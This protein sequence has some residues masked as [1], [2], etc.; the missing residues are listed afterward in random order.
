MKIVNITHACL[1]FYFENKVL[2]TDPWI[3]KDPIKA[4]MVYK[5]PRMRLSSKKAVKNV[6]YCYISHTHEDHFHI[7]SLQKLNK[8][9]KMIIPDF[10]QHKKGRRGR[11]MADTLKKMGFTNI[12]ELKPWKLYE[13]TNKTKIQI[14]PSA[15]SRYF[16]W[17]N[18]GL[19]LIHDG[20]SYLNM[21]DN[22]V[23]EALCRE[24][25]KKIKNIEIYFIQTAGI[26][27]FP[28]CFEMS[29]K[30]KLKKIKHKAEDYKLHDL[31]TKI[32]KP[33]YL[34]PYAGDFGWFGEYEEY[35]YWSR[36]TPEK[37]INYLKNKNINTFEYLPGDEIEIKNKTL[38]HSC[39]FPV[40]W[41]NYKKLIND[42]SA[43]YKKIIKKNKH[44]FSHSLGLN[45]KQHAKKYIESLNEQNRQ[46]DV[47]PNF[48]KSMAYCI[49]KMQ[50]KN[51]KKPLFYILVNA[52]K[53][54]PL[55][56]KYLE[57]FPKDI[58]QIQYLEDKIFHSILRGKAMLNKVQWRSSVKM[59]KKFDKSGRDLL[60]YN[61]YH[62]DGD[63]RTPQIK[64]R[65][66]YSI[67]AN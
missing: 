54:K 12:I 39:K 21:N 14:I 2:L 40:N 41:K 11:L 35:N 47:N 27:I 28:A 37:L 36:S 46:S 52:K 16:D 7:P 61:G 8:N 31:V 63:N 4:G 66:I 18:S 64:L 62:I 1:K 13:L 58:F 30:E 10:S 43:Y 25:K 20:K 49:Y 15:K 33:K 6:D 38:N 44:K 32:I 26:S 67:T 29:K 45:F 17:E 48:S 5:F 3:V 59:L 34:V 19:A 60:F 51:I 42:H 53:N 24:I 9:V 65:K 57:N 55:E 23:D 56:L 50:K 22:V